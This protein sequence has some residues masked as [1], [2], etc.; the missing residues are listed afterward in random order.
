ME[1]NF[2]IVRR[3]IAAY[4]LRASRYYNKQ[5][6]HKVFRTGDLVC[7]KLQAIQSREG[8]GKLAPNWED[9][10]RVKEDLGNGAYYISLYGIQLRSAPA[11]SLFMNA[12]TYV[13][14]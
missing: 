5:V 6:R 12:D 9:P 1:E 13:I 2:D 8:Q 7:R 10:V 4:Q 11:P 3:R 14:A